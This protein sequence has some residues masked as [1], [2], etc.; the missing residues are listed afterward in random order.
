LLSGSGDVL[1]GP[2]PALF[3]AM[4]Y[5]PPAFGLPAFP[6]FVYWKVY[7]E[8][9]SLPSPLSGALSAFSP[10]LLHVS[11]QFIV[12]SVFFFFFCR[13]LVSWPSRLWWFILGVAGGIPCDAWHSSIWCAKCLLSRFGAIIWW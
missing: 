2:L 9:S 5:H 12:Y 13:G 10:P 4:A 3:Q 7:V 11:F 6:D 8:I 1:C